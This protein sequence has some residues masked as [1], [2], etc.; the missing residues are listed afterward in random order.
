MQAR[1]RHFHT[2]QVDRECVRL[3]L[4]SMDPAGVDA[5][6]R[7]RL[8]RRRYLNKGPNYLFH[9][10]GWDKLKPFGLSVHGCVDGFSRRIMWLA[11]RSN[12]DPYEVCNYFCKLTC[13]MNGVPHI[14]R[15]DRGNENVNIERIQQLLRNKNEDDRSASGSTF[16][17]GRSIANQ[18]IES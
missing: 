18:R 11:S 16:L 1:L 3:L 9:I 17:Y 4:R 6:C 12:N 7:G 13:Q 5:R 8:Q 14:I 2:L 15:A 10:D